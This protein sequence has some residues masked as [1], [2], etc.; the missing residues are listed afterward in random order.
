[1]LLHEFGHALACLSVG[2]RV[3]RI[4]LSPLGGATF[5]NP[6]QKPALVLWTIAAGP[7]VNL[8][9]FVATFPLLQ[10]AGDTDLHR[11]L[12]AIAWLNKWL[13]ILNMLPV[14]P[15]DGGQI[16]RA[17]L[18]FFMGRIT[19]LM[20]A[21]IIG[22][23]S[24]AGL[25]IWVLQITAQS[26]DQ[27]NLWNVLIV[28]WIGMGAWNGLQRALAMRRMEQIPRRAEF[29]CPACGR[30]PIAGAVWRCS[31]CQSPFDTFERGAVCP[32]CGHFHAVTICPE[33]GKSSPFAAWQNTPQNPPG[34]QNSPI[35]PAMP[36]M[37][38]QPPP[39]APEIQLP[40]SGNPTG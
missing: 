19:S 2:G 3:E 29:R 1:V 8:A 5:T 20:A 14:F 12:Y 25:L 13:L 17:L 30:P 26:E 22:L 39:G 27:G 35:V 36:F 33:C 10:L 7:L 24:A 21:S 32:R 40:N 34:I 23:I 28:A 15:L 4:V 38:P 11:Y 6:P 31:R 18:W 9:I 16:L 37:P